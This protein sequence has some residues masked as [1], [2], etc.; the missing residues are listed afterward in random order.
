[1]RGGGSNVGSPPTRRDGLNDGLM[2][3]NCSREERCLEL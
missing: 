3:E 2:V 1:M